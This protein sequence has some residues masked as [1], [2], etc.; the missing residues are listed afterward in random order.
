V[1]ARAGPGWLDMY[2]LIWVDPDPGCF[3]LVWDGLNWFCLVT[4][5]Q[6]TY[7]SSRPKRLDFDL[8]LYQAMQFMAH[9]IKNIQHCNCF[10]VGPHK[11][12]LVHMAKYQW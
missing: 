9:M 4:D 2:Q 3:G 12:M 1:W 7:R 11:S 6:K 8:N 5:V 10:L